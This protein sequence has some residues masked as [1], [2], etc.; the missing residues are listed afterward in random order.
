MFIIIYFFHIYINKNMKKYQGIV[1]FKK[2]KE[3][4]YFLLMKNNLVT[5]NKNNNNLYS[6]FV[7]YEDVYNSF[8]DN[9]FGML[10]S[11]NELKYM[12]SFKYFNTKYNH[13]I[14]F[15][16]ANISN[17]SLTK[18]NKVRSYFNNNYISQSK[19]IIKNR[20]SNFNYQTSDDIRWFELSEILENSNNFE[21]KF[22]NTF[23]KSLKNE[24]INIQK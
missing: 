17:D 18:I 13:E 12:N 14:I 3:K 5:L 6:D 22:L 2:E 7:T 9:T 21:N 10:F 16:Y 4:N 8:N 11:I 24:V 23:L 15:I 19:N 20:E 1:L